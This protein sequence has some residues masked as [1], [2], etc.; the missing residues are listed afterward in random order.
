MELIFAVKPDINGNRIEYFLTVNLDRKTFS[1]QD[2][3]ARADDIPATRAT[4]QRLIQQLEAAG[5]I[6]VNF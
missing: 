3:Y 2:R 6:E 4:I 1:R 5:Y